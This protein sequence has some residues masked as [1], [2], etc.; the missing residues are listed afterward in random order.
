MKKF[1]IV[2][3]LIFSGS[4]AIYAQETKIKIE[5]KQLHI[6][7]LDSNYNELTSNP[8][9]LNV[10]LTYDTFFKNYVIVY[11]DI[12]GRRNRIRWKFIDENDAGDIL[13][14]DNHGK[15]AYLIDRI[16]TNGTLSFIG[17]ELDE[18]QRIS[19]LKVSQIK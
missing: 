7:Y 16:E 13:M 3:I 10:N 9:G 1:L 18:Y 17:Y 19:V 5:A 4:D 2:F 8:I 11:T 12:D 14:Q 6:N 15:Y